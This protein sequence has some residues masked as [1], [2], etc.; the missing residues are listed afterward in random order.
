MAFSAAE[1]AAIF[2]V[3]R[4]VS[5]VGVL[6]FVL[7]GGARRIWIWGH[8][9]VELAT[10]LEESQR[11]VERWQDKHL[12]LLETTRQALALAERKRR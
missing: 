2:S 4:D 5:I 6:L 7:W 11:T 12:T 9:Y 10:R 1:L 8:H 3:A